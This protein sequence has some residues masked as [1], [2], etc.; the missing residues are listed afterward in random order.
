MSPIYKVTRIVNTYACK[1]AISNSRNITA[2]TI[3]H[4]KIAIRLIRDTDVNSAQEKP[5]RIFKRACPD[6]MLA[7]NRILKLK[8][9]ATYETSSIKIR[10]GI[11][12]KG[13]PEGKNR[14]HNSH[15]C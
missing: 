6:S 2:V 3:N 12:A 14:L 8:T 13:A 7:N 5:I 10:N 9:R 11:I 15:P 1:K 4:G